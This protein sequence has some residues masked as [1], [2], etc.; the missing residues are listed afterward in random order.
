MADVHIEDHSSLIKTPKQLVVVVL[1]SFIVPIAAILLIVKLITGGMNMDPNA[2]SMSEDAV[3]KRLQPVGEVKLA[4]AN[5]SGGAEAAGGSEKLF[6]TVC[7]ACHAAGLAGAPKT[8]DKAAW[9]P[10]IAQGMDVLYKSALNGK[11][12]MPPKGG[13][14]SASDADVKAAVDILVGKA[15]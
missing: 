12:A 11:N 4:L 14:A 9:K 2:S 3:A 8:G 5:A 6:N 10:R 7:Q 13:D 15:K 1:L